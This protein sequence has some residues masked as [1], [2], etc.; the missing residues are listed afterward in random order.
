MAEFNPRDKSRTSPGKTR[1]NVR[2]FT[3]PPRSEHGSVDGKQRW[4][5]LTIELMESPAFTSLSGNAIRA[6]FRL[7][8]Q[9]TA[10]AALE[11][12]KLVVTHPQFVAYGVTGEYVADALDELEYKGLIKVLRG[13]AGSGVAH[14]NRFTLTFVG[15]HE[16]APPTNEWKQCTPERCRK[17]SD[18]D[19]KIAAEKRGIVGRKK[20]SPLR[21]SEIRPLR[22]SEIRRAS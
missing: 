8:I 18:I 13:R 3:S 9:H 17:W 2:K 20:K 19:R 22:D 12:G 14:P 11:N 1:A 16:G 21:D 5:W 7:L 15:D 4:Q 10:H 6:F